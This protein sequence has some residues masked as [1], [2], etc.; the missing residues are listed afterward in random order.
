MGIPEEVV[1]DQGTQF[2]SECKQGV[3]KLLSIKD[4]TSM[5]NHP[6]CNGLV[7]KWNI[8]FKSMLKRLYQDQPKQWHRLREELWNK[9]DS[10]LEMGVVRP[11]T[12]PYAWLRRKMVLTE[13]MLTLGS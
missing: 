10:M 5:Q 11:T 12:W 1:T 6:I 2:M 4:L 8:T 7:E 9:V 13:C 3:S